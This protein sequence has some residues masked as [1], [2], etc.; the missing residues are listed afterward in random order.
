VSSSSNCFFICDSCC[1]ERDVTSTGCVNFCGNGEGGEGDVLAWPWPF[2][3]VAMIAVAMLKE[4]RC[5]SSCEVG[6]LNVGSWRSRAKYPAMRGNFF[7]GLRRLVFVFLLRLF[8]VIPYH[9]I[10]NLPLG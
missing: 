5:W 8:K 4:V 2:G 1:I 9:N 7:G 6:A 10:Q 3:G